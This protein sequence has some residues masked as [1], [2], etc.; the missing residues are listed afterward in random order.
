TRERA[1]AHGERAHWAERA[2]GRPDSKAKAILEWLRSYLKPG[3][4]WSKERVIIFTEYRATQKWLVDI[5]TAEGF[6]GQDRLMTIY[7]GM[8]PEKR[9]AI[10][11][12]FQADPD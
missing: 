5:L 4:D 1:R 12:A 6:G 9:E 7:G 11:A 3:G 10:K 8:D 2:K